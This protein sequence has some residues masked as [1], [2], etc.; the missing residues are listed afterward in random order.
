MQKLTSQILV[1]IIF[2]QGLSPRI[3]KGT[4][5]KFRQ[6]WAWLDMTGHTQMKVTL[7]HAIFPW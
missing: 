1:K 6:V 3:P 5:D 2:Y 7:S 4:L